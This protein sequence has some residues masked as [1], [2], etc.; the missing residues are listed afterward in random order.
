MCIE[1]DTHA[2]KIGLN[3][4]LVFS[5]GLCKPCK[6][7]NI[8]LILS[9]GAAPMPG[10]GT[11]EILTEPRLV[12]QQRPRVW[13]PRRQ[14]ALAR[15]VARCRKRVDQGGLRFRSNWLQVVMT[16]WPINVVPSVRYESGKNYTQFLS[17]SS[18]EPKGS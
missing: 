18:S 7:V 3:A 6:N 13:S 12:R 10:E 1:V 11:P 8:T 5:L 9:C 15:K 16:G 17:S 14:G 2:S 4:L